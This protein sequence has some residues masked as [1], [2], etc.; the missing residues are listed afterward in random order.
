MPFKS[1]TTYNNAYLNR[2]MSAAKPIKH[3]D[4]LKTGTAWFGRSSYQDAYNNPEAAHTLSF[5]PKGRYDKINN[6]S[7]Q[8]GIIYF[9]DR[10]KL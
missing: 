2:S 7:M 3:D 6:P 8:F 9:Y 10:H 5:K 4:N 1:D